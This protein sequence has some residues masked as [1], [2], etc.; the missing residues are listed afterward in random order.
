MV[1]PLVLVV[2]LVVVVE[3]G[4]EEGQVLGVLKR[5]RRRG[6]AAGGAVVWRHAVVVVEA[7][8]AAAIRIHLLLL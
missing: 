6:C 3:K 5:R 8:G 1:V 7:L 2:A 4:F